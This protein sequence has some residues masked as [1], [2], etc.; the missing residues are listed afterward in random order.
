MKKLL[1]FLAFLAVSVA[2]FA[3]PSPHQ[4]EDALA[5]RDYVSA[6]G[7]VQEVLR[8]RPDSA[9]AHL[10]NAYLLEHVDHN[11]GAAR[12]EL[13]TAAGL[14]TRGDVKGSALFGRVVAEMDAQPVVRAAQPAAKPAAAPARDRSGSLL[15]PFLVLVL[16]FAIVALVIVMT[17]RPRESTVFVDRGDRGYGGVRRSSPRPIAPAPAPA[18][19]SPFIRHTPIYEPALAPVIVNQ[20]P[21][22]GGMTAGENFMAT[23]G[24]VVAGNVLSDALLHRHTHYDDEPRRRREDSAAVADTS[25]AS[26]AT[27][28]PAVD[29]AS[30]RS[31]FSSSSSGSDSWGSSSSDSSSSSSSDSWGGSSDSSSSS[32]SG[33]W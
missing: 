26:A 31:S 13:Q 19:A 23:A 14:D 30:E 4:I 21:A 1:V 17:R 3:L 8:E 27:P 15:V 5:A 20:A 2:A 28:A 22:R 16:L 12:A 9:R 24:G 7:M 10:L 29:Y 6:R 32:D 11:L 25:Y 33:G 18:S